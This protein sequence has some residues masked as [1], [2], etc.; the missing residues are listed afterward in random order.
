M[1]ST[2]TNGLHDMAQFTTLLGDLVLV[3]SPRWHDDRLVFSDW[4]SGEVLAVG[5]DGVREVITH[6]DAIPFCLDRLPDGRLLVV[7]GAELLVRGADE[8]LKQLADLSALSTKPWNDIVSDGRGN[9]YVNNIGFDFP[10]GEFAPGLIALVSQD[11]TPRQVAEDLSFPNG[12]AITPDNSTLIVAESYAGVLTA[13]DIAPDGDLSKRR[14]WAELDGA[15]PD[16][17]CIDAE[18]AVWFAEV[19]GRRCVRVREGGEVVQ[20]I[21]SDLGCF[22]CTLGGPDETTLFVTAAA[23]PDAMTPGSR[24]GQI[25]TTEVSVAGAGWPA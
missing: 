7:A 24:T 5:L 18:G 8:T 19:P 23:W 15:A 10:D 11:G 13:Y 20:T 2:R 25:L 4:G 12:M 16:G 9:A 6:I 22:A 1:S 17:I 21:S 3:E 14:V